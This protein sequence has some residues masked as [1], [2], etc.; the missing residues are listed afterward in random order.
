MTKLLHQPHYVLL[1]LQVAWLIGS[2]ANSRHSS[3]FFFPFSSNPYFNHVAST[4]RS[5]YFFAPLLLPT[6][7][8]VSAAWPYARSIKPCSP[9]ASYNLMSF[10]AFLTVAVESGVHCESSHCRAAISCVAWS[11]SPT[12]RSCLCV[13]GEQRGHVQVKWN[14]DWKY[15]CRSAWRRRGGA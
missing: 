7:L 2:F 15:S 6:P 1:A 5:A 14:T 12:V 8:Y 11:E 10:S 3:T 4:A 9:S 13:S